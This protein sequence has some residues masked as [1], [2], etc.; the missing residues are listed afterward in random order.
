MSTLLT[1]GFPPGNMCSMR[2][3][4]RSLSLVLLGI[5]AAA[6]AIILLFGGD[7][8]KQPPASK[9]SNAAVKQAE[10]KR[11]AVVAQWRKEDVA[12][13]RKRA[14]AKEKY[15]VFQANPDWAKEQDYRIN[16]A[17][18]KPAKLI[19]V[20]PQT[21]TFDKGYTFTIAYVVVCSN[22]TVHTVLS[23]NRWTDG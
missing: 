23:V 19:N 14:A 16:N 1:G 17:C 7:H 21:T 15:D 5:F 2:P 20:A 4:S 3:S 12:L 11:Q 8:R 22:G 10:A 9:T 18:K 6:G 13:Q